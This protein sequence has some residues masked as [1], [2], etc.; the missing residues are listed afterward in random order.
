MEHHTLDVHPIPKEKTP[1][2]INEP[3][4]IDC[5]LLE[6]G[7]RSAE[8]EQEQDNI[9]VYIPLD[10]NKGAILRRLELLIAHYEEANEKNEIDFSIDVNMLVSQI[11]IYDQI[12]FVRHMPENGD[13]SREAVELVREFVT[14]LEEIPD[15][16]AELFPFE[17]IDALRKEYLRQ[18]E[19]HP[20][21][22]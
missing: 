12:W 14:R 13:H 4:L 2:Y 22:D 19:Q 5:S 20:P 6:I 7:N 18:T 1:L 16:C 15:G 11:E 8:P 17:L 3:W 10:I 9:S 21:A